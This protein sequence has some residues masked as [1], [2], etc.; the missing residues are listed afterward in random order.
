M[1]KVL[2]KELKEKILKHLFDETDLREEDYIEPNKILKDRLGKRFNE[3]DNTII[4]NVVEDEELVKEI[5]EI[6]DMGVYK[7]V[8][9]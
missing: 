9:E 3:L 6:T 4:L 2:T 5:N 8:F 1:N 7:N